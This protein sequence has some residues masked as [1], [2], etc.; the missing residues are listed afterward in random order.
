MRK[1]KE[2]LRLKF[3][4]GLT[5][6]Q[7]VRSIGV[8]RSTPEEYFRRFTGEVHDAQIFVSVLGASNY[9]FC[10]ATWTQSLPDWTASHVRAF[11]YFEGSCDELIPDNLKSAVTT[12]SF[13]DPVLNP[14]YEEMAAHYGTA[15]LPAPWRSSTKGSEW[16]P[17]PAASSREGTPPCRNICPRPTASTRSGR[18]PA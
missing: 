2:A 16:R 17:T 18:P 15:V 7:V 5:D 4:C 10:E 8:A 13:Y 12:P 11:E 3:A 9:T 1:I 6:R 14:T